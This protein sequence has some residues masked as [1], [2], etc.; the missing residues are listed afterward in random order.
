M[1]D[2]ATE[3]WVL[4]SGYGRLFCNR[5]QPIKPI[6]LGVF[7]HVLSERKQMTSNRNSYSLLLHI[8]TI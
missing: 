5:L 2:I 6:S 1:A 3:W 8:I 7:D 4:K